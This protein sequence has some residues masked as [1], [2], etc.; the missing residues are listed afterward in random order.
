MLQRVT[1][2]FLCTHLVQARINVG[3]ISTVDLVRIRTR[4]PGLYGGTPL[5]L[6]GFLAHKKPPHRA[7]PSVGSWGMALSYERGTPVGR[8]LGRRYSRP[9]S[10]SEGMSDVPLYADLRRLV[11]GLRSRAYIRLF[12]RADLKHGHLIFVKMAGDP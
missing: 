12:E 5:F 4:V 2:Q 10:G 3:R 7:W 1:M 11:Q 9:T 8:P 6:Q